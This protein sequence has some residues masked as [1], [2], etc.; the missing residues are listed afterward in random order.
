MKTAHITMV[1]LVTLFAVPGAAFA[2]DEAVSAV[3]TG[4]LEETEKY[5]SQ[6]TLGEGRLLACFYAHEDKLSSGCVNAL[7]D[8]VEILNAEINALTE[9]AETCTHDIDKFCANTEIGDG[10]VAK[11]LGY[12]SEELSEACSTSIDKYLEE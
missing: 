5:C 1:A 7:Y 8:A 4:C 11:C 6:V 9:V 3:E 12:H 2:Q 10:R